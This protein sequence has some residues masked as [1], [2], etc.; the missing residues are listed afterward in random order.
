[1]SLPIGEELTPADLERIFQVIEVCPPRNPDHA[2]RMR[3]PRTFAPHHVDAM[4]R[5]VGTDTLTPLAGWQGP[6]S[7]DDSPPIFH[8]QAIRLEREV[9]AKN[10]LL[11]VA[12]RQGMRGH[13]IRELSPVFADSLV[14]Q[15][16]EGVPFFARVAV[17]IDGDRAFVLMGIAR[18]DR[19][20]SLARM[21]GAMVASFRVLTPSGQRTVERWPDYALLDGAVRFQHPAAFRPALL[22]GSDDQRAI[23]SL[24][25]FDPSDV[26]GGIIHVEA[27]RGAPLELEAEYARLLGACRKS[28]VMASGDPEEIGLEI[29]AGPLRALGSRR[30]PAIIEGN[31]NEHEIWMTLLASDDLVVRI[32]MTTPNKQSSFEH[33]ATNRRALEIVLGTLR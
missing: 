5:R 27:M 31:E 7:E 32:W 10:F 2:F 15:S 25:G 17:A 21:F 30:Y 33:W 23:V 16:I 3:V 22:E 24:F 1:M 12:F 29:E 8:V 18:A 4:D 11:L 9:S 20:E 28:G 19:Y 13:F 14:D 26:I 6:G